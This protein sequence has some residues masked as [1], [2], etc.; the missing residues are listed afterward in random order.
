MS[1]ADSTSETEETTSKGIKCFKD[2]R[3][4]PIPEE[5]VS[6]VITANVTTC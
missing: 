6:L 4:V 1:A 2:P 3:L 5:E